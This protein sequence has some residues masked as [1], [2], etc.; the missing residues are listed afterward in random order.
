MMAV[1]RKATRQRINVVRASCHS[2]QLGS[3]QIVSVLAAKKYEAGIEE[4]PI[5]PN[6]PSVGQESDKI[7][8]RPANRVH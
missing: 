3:F 6:A 5:L 4:F 7:K 2:F 8:G 1:V